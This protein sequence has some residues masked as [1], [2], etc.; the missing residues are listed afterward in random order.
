M[1]TQKS[2]LKETGF[3]STNTTV[4]IDSTIRIFLQFYALK[5]CLSAAVDINVIHRHLTKALFPSSKH[6]HRS[7]LP[8]KT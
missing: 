3:L 2:A 7:A 6:G 8:Y 1:G 4:Q 5:F